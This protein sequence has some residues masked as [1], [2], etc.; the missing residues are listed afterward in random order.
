MLALG[1]YW[2][3]L[4]QTLFQ[5]EQASLLR[6][7][8]NSQAGA[9][10]QLL[11]QSLVTTALLAHEVRRSGGEPPDFTVRAA[12]I[13]RDFPAVSSLRLAPAGVVSQIFPLTGN[14]SALGSSVFEQARTGVAAQQ[15]RQERRLTLDGPLQLREG[16]IGVI[17]YNPVFLASDDDGEAFWGFVAAVIDL[18][19]L[20]SVM[21]LDALVQSGYYFEL[22]RLTPSGVE[23]PVMA[24]GDRPPR[25][26]LQTL[27]VRVPNGQWRLRMGRN[28]EEGPG[29]F[30]IGQLVSLVAALVFTWL[31]HYVLREP[32][33]LRTLVESRTRELHQLA[34]HDFLTGLVNRRLLQEELVQALR[35]Q[36]RSGGP[37]HCSISISTTSSVSTTP[38]G[39]RWAIS[40]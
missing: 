36:A 22:I 28:A 37:W 9:I 11:N 10:E 19:P 39:M 3:H 15:A 17:G 27:T 21:D 16:G 29:G 30:W 20:L 34:Y 25:E 4:N 33:R 12:E 2:N 6:D 14:A 8:L 40:C 32:Q 24:G 13:L 23:F 35:E 18:D 31:V 26:D 1:S 7:I 38:W 5:K